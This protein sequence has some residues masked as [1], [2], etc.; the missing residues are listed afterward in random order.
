MPLA[1]G[2]YLY[3]NFLDEFLFISQCCGPARPFDMNITDNTG[4]EV[5]ITNIHHT[6]TIFIVPD[7]P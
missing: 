2:Y 6:I 3:H 5:V 7:P 1:F 4:M